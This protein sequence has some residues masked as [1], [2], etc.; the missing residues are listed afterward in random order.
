MNRLDARD[1]PS[2][3]CDPCGA[4]MHTPLPIKGTV[5][6]VVTDARKSVQLMLLQT[7]ELHFHA[8]DTDS[9]F[10]GHKSEHMH[11]SHE[12]RLKLSKGWKKS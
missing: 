6:K 10:S 4:Q 3:S 1:K 7:V 2:V 9:Q 8:V 11:I 12:S 5:I